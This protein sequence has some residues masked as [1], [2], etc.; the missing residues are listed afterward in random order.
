LRRVPKILISKL[1]K[2]VFDVIVVGAGPSGSTLGFLLAKEGMETLVIDKSLF[3]RPKLC[4]G[5]LTWKTRKLLEDLFGSPFDQLF[6]FKYSSDKYSIYEDHTLKFKGKASEPF[7][8]IDRMDYD[9]KLVS[10]A[11]EE[12]CRFLFN[13]R[14]IDVDAQNGVVFIDEGRSYAGRVIVGA[15]GATSRV[16][17]KLKLRPLNKDNLA[18]AFQVVVPQEGIRLEYRDDTSRL[19]FGNIR[20]GYGWIFSQGGQFVVGMSGLICKNDRIRSICLDFISNVIEPNYALSDPVRSHFLPYR[21]F[22]LQPGINRALLIGDC[23]GFSDALTGEGIYFA[24]K[25]AELASYAIID[26]IRSKESKDL[27]RSYISYLQPLFKKLRLSNK[28]GAIAYSPLRGIAYSVP[29]KNSLFQRLAASVHGMKQDTLSSVF[30][31]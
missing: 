11:R 1:G 6:S 2:N 26:F 22:L 12:Q 31:K 23:A 27:I 25:S 13:S 7:F 14:F 21:D 30:F 3:P 8:F 16:R 29:R 15:D 10:L 24:H 9:S 18:Q 20:Q 19:F 4:A 28:L 17:R 5:A